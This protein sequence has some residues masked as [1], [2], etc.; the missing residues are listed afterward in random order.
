MNNWW[1][2]LVHLL[3]APLLPWFAWWAVRSRSDYV[4][5]SR[6]CSTCRFAK[7]RGLTKKCAECRIYI[8][9]VQWISIFSILI[10]THLLI[11]QQKSGFDL[12]A[13]LLLLD[14]LLIVSLT[15]LWTG[16]IPN[17]LTLGGWFFFLVFR[18]F[19]HSQPFWHYF[20]AGLSI[21][22]GLAMIA[23]LT[24]GMGL[25]DAKLMAVAGWIIGWPH[26]FTAFWLA[27][28][29]CIIYFTYR[30]LVGKSLTK[31]EKIPFAPHLAIGLFVADTW[32]QVGLEWYMTWFL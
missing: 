8:K 9:R 21:G 19:E 18:I 28:V 24:R 32:G 3:T 10:T 5:R 2:G 4:W 7:P 1:I 15:D 17:C 16:M 27:T 12:V 14:F 23:W 25:G 31:R 20:L 22:S 13:S 11:F 26:I 29:S 6:S 30:R